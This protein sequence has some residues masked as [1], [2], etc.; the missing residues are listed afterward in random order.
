MR[1]IHSENSK[2][3][4]A[5]VSSPYFFRK[6]GKLWLLR[7][8]EMVVS[9]LIIQSRVSR[10]LLESTSMSEEICTNKTSI[11]YSK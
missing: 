7:T 6:K 2:S 5:L 4:L 10:H 9:S 11:K 8:R 3:L 1:E